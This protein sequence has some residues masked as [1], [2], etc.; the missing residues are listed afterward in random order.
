MTN[1][2]EQQVIALAGTVQALTAVQAVSTRGEF[3]EAHAL[4]IFYSLINYNSEDTLSAYDNNRFALNY[5]FSQLKKLFSDELDRD[6]AQYILAV[7]SIERKLVTNPNM[8]ALLQSDLLSL[9]NELRNNDSS[10][11]TYDEDDII[12]TESLDEK[13]VRSDTIEQFANL[14]KKT[15][16]NTEPR[17][18]IKGDQQYLQRE[19]SANQIRALLLGALRGAAFFR[20]Y[21]GKRVDFMMKRK[22]YLELIN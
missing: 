5:G 10:P 6:L 19:G 11:S 7:I 18:M 20:H 8:R 15:A 4:P 12:T 2:D 9:C 3:D 16:S 17:I 13:L 21:G 22:T 1:N 14:Y